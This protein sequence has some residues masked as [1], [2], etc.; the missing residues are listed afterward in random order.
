M[1][2]VHS[3]R[4]HSLPKHPPSYCHRKPTLHMCR[5]E[6]NRTEVTSQHL[7]TRQARPRPAQQAVPTHSRATTPS[8]ARDCTHWKAWNL[9]P[10]E[11]A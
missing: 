1:G 3:P 7:H 4:A 6:H 8:A 5:Q 2:A 10:R 11:D 9:E